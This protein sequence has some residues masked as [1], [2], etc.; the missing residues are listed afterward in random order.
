MQYSLIQQESQA[1]R[2]VIF[3]LFCPM[4]YFSK[5]ALL[6]KQEREEDKKAFDLL[7]LNSSVQDRRLNGSCWY[8]VAIRDTELG[9]GDYLTVQF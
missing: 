4:D 9:K 5:L 2:K 8:P 1:G 7:T 6:L 3:P